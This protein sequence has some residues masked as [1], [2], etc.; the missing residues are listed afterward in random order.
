MEYIKTNKNCDLLIALGIIYLMHR[1][2]K[3]GSVSWRCCQ[4]SFS[5]RIK[6]MDE[7][8]NAEILV[9]KLIAGQPVHPVKKKK[10]DQIY[11]NLQQTME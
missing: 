9:E 11:A 5:G 4:K 3:D 10:Y 7:Q 6:N 8:K 2:L 1:I